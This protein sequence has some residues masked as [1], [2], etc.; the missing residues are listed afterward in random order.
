MELNKIYRDK[1]NNR[2]KVISGDTTEL[3]RKIVYAQFID[4]VTKIA[5][6]KEFAENVRQNK[7]TFQTFAIWHWEYENYT[8]I[9]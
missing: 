5:T 8:L 3:N 7:F 9:N 2:I 1:Y 4:R 6:Q